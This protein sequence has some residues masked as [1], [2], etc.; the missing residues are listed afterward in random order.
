[1]ILSSPKLLSC[2]SS[3]LKY[4]N[5]T[6]IHDSTPSNEV[7]NGFVEGIVAFMSIICHCLV[8]TQLSLCFINLDFS[9]GSVTVDYMNF[10]VVDKNQELH[11]TY[12]LK[13]RAWYRVFKHLESSI[14]K[15]DWSFKISFQ[16]FRRNL[17]VCVI[18]PIILLWSQW[19]LT[20][21]RWLQLLRAFI[22]RLS[23]K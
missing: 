11:S 7:I 14:L 9:T 1:M 13:S 15:D 8:G 17:R 10:A 18:I 19:L 5:F 21:F 22:P 12:S 20:F 16:I 6:P 2:G 23:T 4:H 3:G